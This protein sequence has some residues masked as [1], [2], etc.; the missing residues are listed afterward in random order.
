MCESKDINKI[1]PRLK[2]LFQLKTGDSLFL[3]T[4]NEVVRPTIKLGELY[5]KHVAEDGFLYIYVSI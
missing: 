4:K 1:V 5:K 3:F 2:K